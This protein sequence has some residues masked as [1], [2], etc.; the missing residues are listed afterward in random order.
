MCFHC[1]SWGDRE[2]ELRSKWLLY[3]SGFITVGELV[4]LSKVDSVSR[5]LCGM[6]I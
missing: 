2:R 1:A 3:E 5:S 4:T 6:I